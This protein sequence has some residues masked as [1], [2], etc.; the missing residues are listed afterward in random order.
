MGASTLS[1]IQIL[2]V[3]TGAVFAQAPTPPAPKPPPAVVAGIPVNYDEAKVGAYTLPDP[4]R[5]SNGK[6]VRDAKV[7]KEQRRPELIKLFEENQFGRS[8][9]KPSHLSFE[10]FEASAPA[11]DGKAIRRQVT[12][13]FGRDRTPKADLLLYLPA[14]MPRSRRRFC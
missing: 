10:V 11:F 5:L 4:L 1:K 3:A 8:P 6:P 13:H 12:I 7:W 14:A 2:V 9:A